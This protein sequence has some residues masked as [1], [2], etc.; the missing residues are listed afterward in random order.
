VWAGGPK[1]QKPFAK[2]IIK[3]LHEVQSLQTRMNF[4]VNVAEYR[5]AETAAAGAPE[6]N[7]TPNIA[8]SKKRWKKD[9]QM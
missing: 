8:D 4:A 2:K 9:E 6:A 1:F 5:Q 3:E 7:G